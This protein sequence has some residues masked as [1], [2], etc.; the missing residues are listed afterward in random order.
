M[1][2]ILTRTLKFDGRDIVRVSITYPKAEDEKIDNYISGIVKGLERFCE[3]KLFNQAKKAFMASDFFS[4]FSLVARYK[5]ELDSK[6][7]FTFFID[8]FVCRDGERGQIKRIPLNFDRR[9]SGIIF[10]LENI[11]RKQINQ[12]LNISL[13]KMQGREKCYSDY[14]KR[15]YRHFRKTNALLSSK[16]IFA[17]FNSGILACH[18]RGAMNVWVMEN[19]SL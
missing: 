16:G 5:T 7:F 12:M 15:A 2:N 13:S 8:V 11:P 17:T 6:N 14:M 10:P 19:H 3:K 4:P 9:T 1:E 18:E